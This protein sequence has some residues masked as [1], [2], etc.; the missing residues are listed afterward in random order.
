MHTLSTLDETEFQ[1]P[2]DFVHVGINAE[3]IFK[4]IDRFKMLPSGGDLTYLNSSKS[5]THL[6]TSQSIDGTSL[7]TQFLPNKTITQDKTQDASTTICH[8]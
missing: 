4:V 5:K 3:K 2:T 1:I 8:I 6:M 7:V